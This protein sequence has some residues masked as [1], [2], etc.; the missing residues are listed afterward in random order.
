MSSIELI[1]AV[2]DRLQW[3]GVWGDGV[4]WLDQ[5]EDSLGAALDRAVADLIEP[6][7][8]IMC[9][10]AAAAVILMDDYESMPQ[11]HFPAYADYEAALAQRAFRRDSDKERIFRAQR[12]FERGY[13]GRFRGAPVVASVYLGVWG[14]DYLIVASTPDPLK[15]EYDGTNCVMVNRPPV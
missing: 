11:G 1:E 8:L 5:G 12:L 15:V 13:I 7:Q 3:D 6:P 14:G 4:R 10:W 9:S 2:N